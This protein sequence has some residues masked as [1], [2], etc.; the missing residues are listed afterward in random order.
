[1][2]LGC[3]SRTY[4]QALCMFRLLFS[5]K[6]QQTSSEAG[7]RQCN[8]R[9]SPCGLV[10]PV[11]VT[12]HSVQDACIRPVISN[13]PGSLSAAPRKGRSSGNPQEVMP[14]AVHLCSQML[15]TRAS[16]HPCITCHGALGVA[17]SW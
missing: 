17:P 10:V 6:D 15:G 13:A 4:I 11:G 1:M 2:H 16:T 9:T 3:A 8:G 12:P 5:Q 14:K 7:L